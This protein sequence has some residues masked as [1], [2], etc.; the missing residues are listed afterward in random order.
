MDG[1]FP[2]FLT[3]AKRLAQFIIK[4]R[5]NNEHSY[6]LK[7]AC[8]SRFLCTLVALQQNRAQSK[9]LYLLIITPPSIASCVFCSSNTII[10]R[11]AE[12]SFSFLISFVVPSFRIAN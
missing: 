6:W 4:F 7:K 9:L 2:E 12:V 5:Y 1:N 3:W 10:A 11:S 8:S